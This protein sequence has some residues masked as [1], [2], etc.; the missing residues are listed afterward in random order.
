MVGRF[1]WLL[2]ATGLVTV[3]VARVVADAL[4]SP[5]SRPSAPAPARTPAPA[6]VSVWDGVYSEAQAKRGAAVYQDVCAPCH[7]HD[8]AGGE[9]APPLA[10]PAFMAN[11]NGLTL[12]DLYDRIRLTMPPD[13]AGGLPRQDTIDTIA[14]VL[15]ANG[16]PAG[17]A[18]LEARAE[19]LMQIKVEATRGGPAR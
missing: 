8:L 2:A 15:R 3:I 5:A 11:W 16:F 9:M 7:G 1:A 4:P 17:K 10:G 6:A 12:N 14:Y 18:A 19:V 13:R